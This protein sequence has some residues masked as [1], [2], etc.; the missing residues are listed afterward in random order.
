[1]KNFK[2][3]VINS[4]LVFIIALIFSSCSTETG[5]IL[6]TWQNYDEITA[7][8]S[9]MTFDKNNYLYMDNNG[10]VIG[11]KEFS[12]IENEIETFMSMTYEVD[13]S[14]NPHWLD[15]VMHINDVKPED[16][17]DEFSIEELEIVEDYLKS[18]EGGLIAKGIFE[19]TDDGNLKIQINMDSWHQQ[20]NSLAVRPKSFDSYYYSIMEKIED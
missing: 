17:T 12:V 7:E 3:K 14:K 6:G 20:D 4:V 10:E 15:L 1:M 5:S 19:F 13:Y 8:Y 18:V 2:Q 11:G 16:Q 9:T